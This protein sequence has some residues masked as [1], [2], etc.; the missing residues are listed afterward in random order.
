M[1][2]IIHCHSTININVSDNDEIRV[3]V[4][5]FSLILVSNDLPADLLQILRVFL[6]FNSVASSTVLL[7]RNLSSGS[8]LNRGVRGDTYV[9]GMNSSMGMILQSLDRVFEIQW[10]IF[11]IGQMG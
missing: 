6:F 3:F 4:F 1:W 10:D 8:P 11:G 2:G 9:Q 7:V 5:I